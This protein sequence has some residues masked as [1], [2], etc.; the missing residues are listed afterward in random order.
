[1]ANLTILSQPER[2]KHNYLENIKEV[3]KTL[4]TLLGIGMESETTGRVEGGSGGLLFFFLRGGAIGPVLAVAT[5]LTA[6]S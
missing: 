1:M 5:Q 6:G 4:L 2:N 3:D